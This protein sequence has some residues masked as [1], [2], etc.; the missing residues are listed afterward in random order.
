MEVNKQPKAYRFNLNGFSF[1][2]YF[3]IPLLIPPSLRLQVLSVVAAKFKVGFDI[4]G[5]ACIMCKLHAY[6]RGSRA[7][8]QENI[9]NFPSSD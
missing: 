6:V 1:A 4:V 9:K 5:L 2:D 8:P 3:R 7:C